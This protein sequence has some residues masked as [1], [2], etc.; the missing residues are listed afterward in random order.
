MLHFSRLTGVA[1]LAAALM[2]GTASAQ[3][4]LRSSDTH[5]DGYP[6][7]E[8]VKYFGELV[9][10]R[11]AG[12]YAVELYHSAQLGEE[13]DTIEQVRTGVIDLN[14][15]SMAPFNGLIPETTVPSL[16]YIFRSEDH[17]HK[18]MD[19][20]VGD[21]IAAAFEQVGLVLLAFYDSGARSFYNSKKPI[22]SLADL[23]GM[24]F[25]VIQSDIFV[26][27]VAALGAN[28][29]PMP[30]GE[31][32]SAIETGVIDGAENNFPSY[33]T[34]KHAEVAK[35]YS[36]DEHTMVPEAFVMAKSSWDKLTPEDQA[37]FKA[38]AKESVARQRELWTAK[39]KESRA[40]VEAAGSQITTPD[41]QPF[42]D[43]MGPVYEK[44]V[45]DD[46]L[47]AMVEAIK[48]VQ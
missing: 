9:K 27:M 45:K 13:K 12:R 34:A 5:P 32:Y 40:K 48:A 39:V 47:K 1:L 20:A 46:K 10:E 31:V 16:P 37:I 41:K 42:I 19:G 14:R 44:H 4:V 25:R 29:T 8:A 3:T 11:T 6:T 30:Y 43:A 28:A 22:N 24:K 21:Q 36:L 26:D 17:M 38:A 35:F 2:A 15:I 23:S 33:D 7:V 18:V